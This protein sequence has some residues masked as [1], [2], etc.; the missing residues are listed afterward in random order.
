MS[1]HEVH[2]APHPQSGATVERT[3]RISW[4]TDPPQGHATVSVGSRAIRAAPMSFGGAEDGSR[5]TDAGELMAAA[6]GS[7]VAAFLAQI[8]VRD[9]TPAHELVVNVTYA[10]PVE[11]LEA[12]ELTLYV[13]GRVPDSDPTRFEQ[14]AQE[15]VRLCAASFGTPEHPSLTLTARLV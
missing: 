3:A 7:A 6:H 14:A 11:W 4:L 10:F 12:A 2:E 13:E 9:G 15:A 5:V 8:L 1:N